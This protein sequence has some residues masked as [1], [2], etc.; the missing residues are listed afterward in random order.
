MDRRY[1]VVATRAFERQ[2]RHLHKRSPDAYDA[3]LHALEL[4]ETDPFNITGRADIRKLVHVPSG[5]GQFRL[6]IGDYRLRYDVSGTD[7]VLHSIRPR[8]TSYR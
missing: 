8:S 3:L 2:A 7:V 6:R 1:R 5:E 4:L